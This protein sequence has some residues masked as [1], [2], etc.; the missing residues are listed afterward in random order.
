MDWLAYRVARRHLVAELLTKQWLM[1]VRRGWLSLLKP[2]I[3]TFDDVFRA[4]GK[5]YQFTKN[6]REQVYNVRQILHKPQSEPTKGP[7]EEEKKFK[8]RLKDHEK[9]IG[10]QI[11]AR[12]NTLL[13]EIERAGSTA[14]HWKD[15]YE[16][17][18]PS[19]TD[20]ERS[21]GEHM[22][23]LYTTNFEG[24]I[25]GAKPQRGGGGLVREAP[26]T[27]FLDDILKLLYQEAKE[28]DAFNERRE[29][30]K[31]DP[32][33]RTQRFVEE[34]PP[35]YGDPVFREFNMAGV[36]VVVVDP[37]HNGQRI[38]DYV[39][40]VE[41]AHKDITRK[42]FGQV[43]YGVFFLMSDSYEKLSK[44]EQDAYTKAGYK[45]LESR[46][47]SYHSGSDIIRIMAPSSPEIVHII[48]HELGHR[49]WYKVMSA[50]QRARFESLI[51]GD[52]SMV[53]AILLNHHLLG[54][55]EH[56]LYSQLLEKLESGHDLSVDEKGLIRNKFKELGLRGGVPLVS[57]YSRSR[58]TEAF[59]EVFE[60]YVVDGDLTRD[61]VDS[62]RSVL[63]SDFLLMAPALR[64]E[65]CRDT[66]SYQRFSPAL[67]VLQRP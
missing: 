67:V 49:Y 55:V 43:W 7:N 5:L 46:A 9:Y 31:Q 14:E 24:A 64:E 40:Y 10:T 17:R 59:A 29:K 6:L 30:L 4:L 22:L 28:I 1:A 8:E 32:S 23:N 34:H 48:A 36:K 13:K 52:W 50:G 44:Q 42:G 37:K 25:A 20:Y 54:V 3:H 38:R 66:Y 62:F 53:H 58:P 41:M 11:E 39:Q 21:Q 63:S 45:N 19:P 15:A 57:D 12:F 61:Q 51:E 56:Q 2:T 33:E 35:V 27:E 60:R 16:G 47:G 18:T 26:L 65:P